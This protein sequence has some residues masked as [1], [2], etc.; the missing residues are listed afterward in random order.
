MESAPGQKDLRRT[1]LLVILDF[2]QEFA[3]L[4]KIINKSESIHQTVLP[5]KTI[6]IVKK[7]VQRI[8]EYFPKLTNAPLP[9]QDGTSQLITMKR[10]YYNLTSRKAT[11]AIAVSQL[12]LD[13]VAAFLRNEDCDPQ[14]VIKIA[15]ELKAIKNSFSEFRYTLTF[16]QYLVAF[17]RLGLD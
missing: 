12:K 4:Q 10:L 16:S 1:C 13:R 7:Q 8:D 6:V 2:Q 15:A 14:L 17:D 5:A 3:R 11:Y 9:P